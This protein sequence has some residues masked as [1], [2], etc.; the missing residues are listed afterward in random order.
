MS[1]NCV[2]V[3]CFLVGVMDVLGAIVLEK[4]YIFVKT[5]P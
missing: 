5:C 1:S 3:A 4:G 2:Y